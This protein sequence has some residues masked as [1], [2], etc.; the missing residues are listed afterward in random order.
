MAVAVM[1]FNTPAVLA[2]E[3]VAPAT[4]TVSVQSGDTLSRIAGQHQ[5]TYARLFDANEHIKNPNL[6]YVGNT[7]RIPDAGEQLPDRMSQVASVS[8]PAPAAAP[9]PAPSKRQVAPAPRPAAPA[10]TGSVSTSVWDRL[11]VCESGG[12][13]SINTGNGYYGGLQFSLSSWRAVGGGGYPHQ[14][15]KS[16]QIAR[17]E[18][19][20][21]KQGWGAWPACT[22]KMG[23]R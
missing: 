19:L 22:A 2:T 23:L 14:A 12:N 18:M 6:I 1:A 7:I 21:A 8:M 3:S 16:E 20:L 10:P 13:W 15:S 9:V 5:T 17:A 11:A 4:N